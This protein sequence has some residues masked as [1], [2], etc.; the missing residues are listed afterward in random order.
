MCQTRLAAAQPIAATTLDF[1]P[2]VYWEPYG[3]RDLPKIIEINY[4]PGSPRAQEEKHWLDAAASQEPNSA[5]FV[6]VNAGFSNRE[7]TPQTE[8]F[9]YKGY[10][11][12]FGEPLIV[13]S[14]NI[15]APNGGRYLSHVTIRIQQDL[16][17]TYHFNNQQF[18]E[19][20][21]WPLY[22]RVLA[23]LEF[24]QTPR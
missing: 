21:W 22:Q 14:V 18:S 8:T 7:E 12:K 20:T 3:A 15:E 4:G 24:L 23:F 13:D 10:L 17:L 19:N 9:L 6:R 2:G 11:N 16:T 5:G 1:W